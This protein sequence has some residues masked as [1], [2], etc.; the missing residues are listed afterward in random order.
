M[1]QA[2]IAYASDRGPR[3][4]FEDAVTALQLSFHRPEP[5]DLLLGLVCDGAG[6]NPDGDLASRLAVSR[7]PACLTAWVAALA[8]LPGTQIHDRS[9]LPKLLCKAFRQA[10]RTILEEAAEDPGRKGMATTAVCAAVAN[11]MLYLAWVGDSPCYLVRGEEICKLTRDHSEVQELIDAGLIPAEHAKGHPLANVITRYLGMEGRLEVDTRSIPLRD[12][13]LVLLFTD[14]L[15]DVLGGPEILEPVQACREGSFSFEEL[16]GRLV[17][18]AITAG[19]TD[20]ITVL[21]FLYGSG[22]EPAGRTLTGDY[23]GEIAQI[24]H[25]LNQEVCV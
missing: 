18:R 2:Q 4:S 15:T 12:S 6:G 5:V 22:P 10:N 13:D 14:G 23:P 1:R 17:R 8:A 9:V 3:D 7:I 21:C 25:S 20:N 11:D 16:P 19:T 24:L